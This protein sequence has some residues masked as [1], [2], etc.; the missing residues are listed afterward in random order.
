MKIDKQSFD[1]RVCFNDEK[2]KYF[3]KGKDPDMISVTTLIHRY[4]QEF[5]AEFWSRYKALQKLVGQDEFDGPVTTTARAKVEKRSPSSTAKISLLETKKYDHKWTEFYGLSVEELEKEAELI[6]ISYDEEREKSCF[7]GTGIHK[8]MENL[9]MSKSKTD[10]EVLGLGGKIPGEFRFSENTKELIPGNI[11]PE[12]LL[13][14]ISDDGK[15]RVAGQVD[16]LVIDH[17]GGVYI[18][19]FKGLP[20]D[21]IIPTP[22]GYTT[23][24]EI[25]PGDIVFDK[26]GKPTKVLNI[27]S[28]HDNPCYKIKFDN[29]ESITCDH[30]H[31][32]EV[33]FYK[34]KN[35]FVS[36]VMTTEEIYNFMKNNKRTSYTIPK[37]FNTKPLELP[38]VDLPI[39]PYILGAWL[40]DGSKSCGII[41]NINPDFWDEVKKRGYDTGENLSGE[42][43]AEMRTV[44]N[45]RG[46]LNE[47][48]LLNNKH[49]PSLYLR[50]S[51]KQRLDLLR[52]LMDTDGH[53][54][55]TRKRFVMR[56]TQ[57][58][59]AFDLIELVSSLGWKPTL[60]N[61]NCPCNDKIFPG[62]DVCF[63]A[64]E[65]P[66][67]IRNQEIE[68]T[69]LKDNHSFRNIESIEMVDTVKTK[70]IEV[71]SKTHTFLITRSFIPTHNT[72]KKIDQKS[73]FNQ[74][75]KKSTKMKYPLNNLDDANFLHYSLQLSLYMWMVLKSNPNLFIKGLYII[76]YD[77]DGNT[78]QY[79]CEYLKNDVERML[80]YY[81]KELEH[82]AFK[83]ER[84]KIV[85]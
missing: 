41:T 52:G 71:D 47:L 23:I 62:Y 73:Y 39:D 59:Q 70:C 69:Q 61:V 27:S 16:L 14:R 74:K 81:K 34:A 68:L 9:M 50:S 58:W 46:K 80:A 35:K 7:R 12:I 4:T 24:E 21:T 48:G 37:I 72:N 3:E 55:K 84:E 31:K 56:T 19:D 65:N 67:L 49:I 79:E 54:N 18:V 6:R 8:E 44:L 17:D 13:Y 2:H 63:F 26:L 36:K 33:S 28:I 76:H 42:D 11:Y 51:H 1:E 66:F 30:E 40:G 38:D 43:R 20:L 83:K 29:S 78:T 25:K 77:H 53:Y 82:Q 85:F 75:T 15:L 57:K 22:T 60:F 5:D 32:W 64:T 45:I 10:M